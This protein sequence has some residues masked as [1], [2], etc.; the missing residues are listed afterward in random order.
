VGRHELIPLD[1]GERW[2]TALADVPHGHA[3]THGFCRAVQLTSGAR[4]YLYRYESQ[5]G[6]VVCALAEREHAGEI[7]VTTPYGFGGFAMSGG[8][9]GFAAAWREFAR[10]RGWVCG[11]IALNPLFADA[12]A[13]APEEVRVHNR[14]Y[15]LDLREPPERLWARL[16]RNRRRQLRDWE[17][18]GARLELDRTRLA[19]FLVDNFA[20][21][22]ARRGAGPATAFRR[23]TVAAIAELHDVQLVGTGNRGLDAV[24]A[25]GYTPHAGDALFAVSRPGGER[26]SARLV[27]WGVER[28][29][30]LGVASLN[31]GGGI[32]EGDDVAEF[33][34]R[35]GAAEAPLASLRQVYRPDVYE[36]LCAD[37]GVSPERSGWFPPYRAR[38]A[39]A[40]H[41]AS[42][43][44]SDQ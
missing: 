37:A 23:H 43:A 42:P 28:L 44:E 32:R 33:K 27:W 18:I 13:F 26:H 16:S 41:P 30:E 10:E 20:A 39:G 24:A 14:L 9:A 40:E 12:A 5:A 35:F 1:D 3:H 34:R 38:G 31:L 29:R 19:E 22:F 4:T 21:F 11:Y 17:A 8:C 25:F 15:L 6:R 36:R 7:D 2:T